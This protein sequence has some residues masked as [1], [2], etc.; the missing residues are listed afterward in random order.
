MKYQ[1]AVAEVIATIDRKVSYEQN[2]FRAFGA[3]IQAAETPGYDLSNCDDVVYA[4]A[5][6]QVGARVLKALRCVSATLA[7]LFTIEEYA[8]REVL[9][10]AKRGTVSTSV[11]SNLSREME[12]QAWAE[13]HEVLEGYASEVDPAERFEVKRQTEMACHAQRVADAAE[14]RRVAEERQKEVRK[15]RR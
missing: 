12:L 7:T 8:L 3:T 14:S 1:E 2:K 11:T 5:Y 10:R 4:A 15:R 13:I 9:R 6:A